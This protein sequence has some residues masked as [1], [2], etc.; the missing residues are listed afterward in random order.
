MSNLK[1][2]IDIDTYI[3]MLEERKNNVEQWFGW[4]IPDI[5]WKYFLELLQEGCIPFNS[6][7]HNVIDNLAV[8]GDYGNFDEYKE[9]NETDEDF[10]E[11]VQDEVLAIFP[12][13]RFLIYSL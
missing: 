3:D 11:R 4:T 7:P 2:E 12:E 6:D 1:I 9:E 5:V 8:N 10:I 13:Q